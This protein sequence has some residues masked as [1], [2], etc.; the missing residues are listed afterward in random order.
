MYMAESDRGYLTGSELDSAET[1][2]PEQV[3]ASL[4][5]Q[6]E[7]GGY[8]SSRILDKAMATC[9]PPMTVPQYDAI[10]ALCIQGIEERSA[11]GL[12]INY[13]IAGG[14]LQK[15]TLYAT[16][17]TYAEIIGAAAQRKQQLV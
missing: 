17:L 16:S 14:E 2:T 11:G 6:I 13:A 1:V 9:E 4:R 7:D 12:P 15:P 10:M 3:I 5:G 8:L